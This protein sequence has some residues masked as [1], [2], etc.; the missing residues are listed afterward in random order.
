MKRRCVSIFVVAVV[1][2]LL[3]RADPGENGRLSVAEYRAKLDELLKASEELYSSGRAM[4]DG[5]HSLPARWRIQAEAQEFTVST[6]GLRGDVEKFKKEQ[7]FTNAVAIRERIR[8]LRDE[9][10]GFERPPADFSG[11]RTRLAAILAR[12]EFRDVQGPTFLDRLKQR[13][14]EAILRLLE[15]LLQSSAIPTISK[16]LVYGLI[17][18]A[19]LTLAFVAYR[20]LRSVS[21]VEP[22]A[23]TDLPVS[24]TSWHLWLSQARGAAAEKNWRE[25]IHLA[26]WAGISF[27]E[28]QGTWKPDRAR[29]PREYLRLISKTSEHRE[30][31]A[32]LTQSFELTWYAM[33]GADEAAFLRA[34]HALEKLGCQA[35]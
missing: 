7:S 16:Y 2:S 34:M 26:Y 30:T 13:I 19:V 3:C 5:L 21:R 32:A 10:G 20:Y 31:L 33:R 14:A 4:P 17:G 6:E 15:F 35:S 12:P 8:E 27:L 11:S 22:V 25:A 24:A 28:Q 1:A 18:L 29:T 9:A 23:P